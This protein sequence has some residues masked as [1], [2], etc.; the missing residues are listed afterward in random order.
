MRKILLLEDN[1]SLGEALVDSLEL[2]GFSVDWYRKLQ[3]VRERLL[4]GGGGLDLVIL[5]IGL[6][7]GS[8]MELAQWIKSQWAQGQGLP[9]LF[10]TAMN[11]AENRLKAFE[12]GAEEFIPKPFHFKELLLRIEH[13]LEAH[14]R[15]P[16]FLQVHGVRIDFDRKKV[17]GPVSP[18]TRLTPR[19]FSLLQLLV[20]HSPRVVSRDEILDQLLGEDQFP[21]HRT[22]DN[23]IVRLRQVLKDPEGQVI[24]SIRGVGYQWSGEEASTA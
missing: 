23:S 7:D 18:G 24:R 20:K 1:A 10:M 13:V 11:T 21:S 3:G 19:D 2:E 4:E 12:L 15:P 9:F 8:G 14:K 22:V 16:H 17:E 6:P 5:D